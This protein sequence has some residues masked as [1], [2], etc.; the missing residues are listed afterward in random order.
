MQTSLGTR[1][2][3]VLR[4]RFGSGNLPRS[5]REVA[6]LLGVRAVTVEEIERRALRKLRRSALGPVSKGW[7]GWDEV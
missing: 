4:L 3:L 6:K 7:S 1:E 5:Q 2:H